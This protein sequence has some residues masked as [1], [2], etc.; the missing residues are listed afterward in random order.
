MRELRDSNPALRM[1]GAFG[2]VC[3]GGLDD[4]H[5]KLAATGWVGST[6]SNPFRRS[7]TRGPA[8]EV[9][10]AAL[11]IDLDEQHASDGR[12]R[13]VPSNA[14]VYFPMR[15]HLKR[16]WVVA[17]RSGSRPGEFERVCCRKARSRR[18]RPEPS[19]DAPEERCSR[20]LH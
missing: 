13:D 10:R 11:V 16:L 14:T 1:K 15:H 17:F 12:F 18:G 5:A 4:A 2:A 19:S 20:A 9:D 6:P 8:N 3:P 7:A